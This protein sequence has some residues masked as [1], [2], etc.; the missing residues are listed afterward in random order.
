MSG[1]ASA[2]ALARDEIRELLDR[3]PGRI[4]VGL[5]GPPGVGKSTF[6]RRLI[7]EFGSGAALVPMD[8]FHLSSVQLE[9]LG[10][11]HRKGAPD[12]FDVDGYVAT[13]QR[14]RNAHGSGDVYVPAFDRAIEE[15]VAAGLVVPRDVRL[16]VTEGNYLALS[17]GGWS[18]VRGLLDRL[19]YLDCPRDVRRTRLVER[20]VAGGRGHD[21]ALAWVDSVDEPNADVIVATESDCDATLSVATQA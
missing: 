10:R 18:A 9:R 7:D 2:E 20:H 8:G 4:V 14:I 16:V 13:L 6:A 12:T 19:Y 5:T 21:D 15:P 17:D 3:R 11:G 1:A